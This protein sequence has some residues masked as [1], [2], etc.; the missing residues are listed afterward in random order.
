VSKMTT[1]SFSDL[2]EVMERVLLVF[3]PS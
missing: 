2:A 3:A 1:R